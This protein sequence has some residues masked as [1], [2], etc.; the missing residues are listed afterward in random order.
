[1][2]KNGTAFEYYPNSVLKIHR[3]LK[4]YIRFISSLNFYE[5]EA[6]EVYFF[7]FVKIIYMSAVFGLFALKYFFKIKKSKKQTSL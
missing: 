7:C 4:V 3:T 6:F 2:Y 5:V 1:M